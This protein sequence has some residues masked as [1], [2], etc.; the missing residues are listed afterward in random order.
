MTAAPRSLLGL[1]DT[2]DPQTARSVPDSQLPYLTKQMREFLIDEV[3]AS[4]GHPGPNVGMTEFTLALRP[5]FGFPPRRRRHRHRLPGLRTQAAHRPLQ[6]IRAPAAGCGLSGPL[7]QQ[8]GTQTRGKLTRFHSP[9]L[10]GRPGQGPRPGAQRDRTVV[11]ASAALTTPR[12]SGTKRTACTPW[13][14]SRP[15]PG[16][17]PARSRHRCGPARLAGNSS[18]SPQKSRTLSPRG[19]SGRTMPREFPDRFPD[20][21]IAGQSCAQPVSSSATKRRALRP[22]RVPGTAGLSSVLS[23]SKGASYVA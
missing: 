10:R 22:N 1:A 15:P 3:C 14:P 4:G 8:V 12:P 5:A 20:A 16:A 17:R 11:A 6:G 7:A 9:L 13:A 19:R 21:G 18:K 2:N 23:Y